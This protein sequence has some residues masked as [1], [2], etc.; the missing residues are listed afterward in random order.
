MFTRDQAGPQ[1][2]LNRIRSELKDP[3]LTPTQLRLLMEDY[4]T[5]SLQ[6]QETTDNAKRIE[7]LTTSKPPTKLRHFIE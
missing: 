1:V 7:T 4:Q 5:I 3:S 6:I 2:L